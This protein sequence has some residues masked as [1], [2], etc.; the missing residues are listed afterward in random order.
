MRPLHWDVEALQG[1][2][3]V[4]IQIRQDKSKAWACAVTKVLHNPLNNWNTD[5]SVFLRM[6]WCLHTTHPQLKST[7]RWKMTSFSDTAFDIKCFPLFWQYAESCSS[8]ERF[9]WKSVSLNSSHAWPWSDPH[10]L[11]QN[12]LEKLFMSHG[13]VVTWNIM[14]RVCKQ[15]KYICSD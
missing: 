12:I 15:Y 5:E 8:C 4:L 11:Q 10:G 7:L 3:S 1:P 14:Q 9:M 6:L 2:S 13:S